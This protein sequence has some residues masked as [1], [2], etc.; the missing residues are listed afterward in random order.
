MNGLFA[1]V[2]GF[3]LDLFFGDPLWLPHPV[4]AMGKLISFLEKVLRRI[5][6]KTPKGELTAGTIMAI[7]LPLVSWGSRFWLCGGFG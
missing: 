2:I 4:V 5:F 6:P 1:M 3:I 7:V